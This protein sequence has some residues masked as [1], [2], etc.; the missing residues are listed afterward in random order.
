MKMANKVV[1]IFLLCI[2]IATALNMGKVLAVDVSAADKSDDYKECSDACMNFC[3]GHTSCEKECDHECK[4]NKMLRAEITT[5]LKDLEKVTDVAEADY[6]EKCLTGCVKFCNT[7]DTQCEMKCHLGCHKL[8]DASKE[9]KDAILKGIEKAD[10]KS[11]N[12]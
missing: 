2:I 10:A 5:V 9:L 3:K 8:K 1:A 12:K 4:N 6:Y 11:K 7:G